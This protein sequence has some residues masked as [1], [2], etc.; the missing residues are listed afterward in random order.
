VGNRDLAE[1]RNFLS[2]YAAEMPRTMLRYSIEKLDV[3]ER[4][5]WLG[6]AA[7]TAIN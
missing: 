5:K 7:K 4:T 1:L 3:E 6:M 2:R